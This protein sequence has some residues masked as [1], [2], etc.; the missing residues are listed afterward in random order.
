MVFLLISDGVHPV[1]RN[2]STNDKAMA[3]EIQIELFEW[4]TMLKH[5]KNKELRTHDQNTWVDSDRNLLK[6]SFVGLSME[7]KSKKYRI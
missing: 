7:D 5:A 3:Q 4:S 2:R 1:R 6:A